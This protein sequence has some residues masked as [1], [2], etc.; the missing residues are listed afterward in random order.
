MF[1]YLCGFR[2]IHWCSKNGNGRDALNTA[3]CLEIRG[4]LR[5]T[6]YCVGSECKSSLCVEGEAIEG[7]CALEEESAFR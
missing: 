3:N 6:R 5:S 2:S 4:I 1:P 7:W